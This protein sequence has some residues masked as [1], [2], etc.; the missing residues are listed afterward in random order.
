MGSGRSSGAEGR[1]GLRPYRGK[2]RRLLGVGAAGT[3]AAAAFA[4]T[5]VI[6]AHATTGTPTYAEPKA[7]V[8]IGVGTP[9]AGRFYM[10]GVARGTKIPQTLTA[11]RMDVAWSVEY[12]TNSFLFGEI[13]L[14]TYSSAGA[15]VTT[16]ISLFPWEYSKKKHRLTAKILP[17]DTVSEEKPEGVPIGT[18]SFEVPGSVR[19][20]SQEEARKAG[21]K[22]V[23]ELKLLK[24]TLTM[25]GHGPYTV[26]FSREND[27]RAASPTIPRPKS[28]A[29]TKS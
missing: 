27:T 21:E 6:T 16:T 3:L 29:S 24:G 14:R 4:L 11:A 17:L 19:E 18:L 13:E 2:H 9:F 22:A 23:G 25:N 10:S 7:K 26:E 28:I 8:N 15:P 20:W 1:F 12:G 5:N